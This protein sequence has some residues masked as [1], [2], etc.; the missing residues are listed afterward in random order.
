VATVGGLAA[1]RKRTLDAVKLANANAWAA[2]R[3]HF[4]YFDIAAL[5]AGSTAGR[6]QVLKAD[7]QKVV[8][9][10]S[11]DKAKTQTFC[12][13]E[14]LGNQVDEAIQKQDTKKAYELT[15]KLTELE[16]DLGSEYLAL[17]ESLRSMDLTSKDGQE[18]MSTFDKLDESCPH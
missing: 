17:V 8:A 15:Q 4:G 5:C 16:K 7:A 11:S 9:I 12:Q 6:G 14:I 1:A 10:I 2:D 18:I 3:C 13:M